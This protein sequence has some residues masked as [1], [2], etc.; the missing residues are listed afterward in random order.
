MSIGKE[1][2][3]E[4]EARDISIQEMAS[5]TKIVSRYLE[6]LEKDEL[7]IMPGAFFTKGIIRVYARY[8]GLD[9]EEVLE[10]YRR[11]GLLTEDV[12]GR[13]PKGGGLSDIPGKNRLVIGAVLIIVLAIIAVA[14][15]F[16]W[17]PGGT[18]SALEPKVE[19]KTPQ[20]K[21]YLPKIK[22]KQETLQTPIVE[23]EP[24]TF[25]LE[26]TFQEQTWIQVYVDGILEFNGERAPG[27]TARYDAEK[28]FVI[29]VGNAGGLTFLLNGQP[30]KSL[31]GLGEVVKDIRINSENY[32]EFLQEIET[33]DL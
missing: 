27:E 6:A 14:V 11:S 28:E 13:S 1:L 2:K 5:S 8:I 30:G 22:E 19:A 21:D 18:P 7:H 32:K 24:E 10:K 15:L 31:G 26:L 20:I 25:V 4:R 23:E 3:A 29:N 12:S 33:A 9:E 16:I 17:K